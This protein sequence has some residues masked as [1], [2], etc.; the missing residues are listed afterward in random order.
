MS[1]SDQVQVVIRA[2][3]HHHFRLNAL[4]LDHRESVQDIEHALLTQIL[5]NVVDQLALDKAARD[6][7]ED[8]LHDDCKFTER[9]TKSAQVGE[10]R[11]GQG[12]QLVSVREGWHG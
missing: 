8:W 2:I 4:Y 1:D 7:A 10:D 9:D 11:R 12:R 6:R 5:P 3:R